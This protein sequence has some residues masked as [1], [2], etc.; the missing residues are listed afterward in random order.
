MRAMPNLFVAISML[1]LGLGGCAAAPT[2]PTEAYPVWWSPSLGIEGLDDVEKRLE[3]PA[4]FGGG[5]PIYKGERGNR[6]EAIADNCDSLDRLRKEGY[7]AYVTHSIR[8]VLYHSA[9]CHV[10]EMLLEAMPAKKS[11]VRDFKLDADSINYLP[12]LVDAS[13]SCDWLCRQY[14][15]NERRIPFIEFVDAEH[16]IVDS[17]SDYRMDV[18]TFGSEL[19]MEILARADFNGD[20]LE[21]LL[22]RVNA[23]AIG[24]TWGTTQNFL[25][26]RDTPDGVLWVLGAEKKICSPV[27]YRPCD[28]DYDHPEALRRTN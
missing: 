15:A 18:K 4:W 14:V 28:A 3:D 8:V 10:I 1:V 19:T 22:L 13:P 27:R 20:G 5:I 9:K 25:L 6:Q 7:S 26:T 16:L 11:H 17:T 21:D 2:Q 24:G 23:G 12:A